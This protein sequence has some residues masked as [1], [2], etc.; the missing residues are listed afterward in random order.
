MHR[1]RV[2]QGLIS[3]LE[4]IKILHRHLVRRVLVDSL[5]AVQAVFSELCQV[6]RRNDTGLINDCQQ[7]FDMMPVSQRNYIMKILPIILAKLL[8]YLLSHLL[9]QP[10]IRS[11]VP[12]DTVLLMP[13]LSV[14]LIDGEVER[15][16]Q[17]T[18]F[19]RL[20]YLK[21]V[22]KPVF[23]G[24]KIYDDCYRNQKNHTP[25]QQFLDRIFLFCLKTFHNKASLARKLGK[26]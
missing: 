23:T 24:Q 4:S 5:Y 21:L 17:Q 9:V 7:M 25:P 3:L 22:V 11:I 15:S 14:I 1:I 8:D 19:P 16:L 26:K 13:H 2:D 6:I 18:V 20:V 10:I 12:E